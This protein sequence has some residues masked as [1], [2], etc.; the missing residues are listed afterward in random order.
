MVTLICKLYKTIFQINGHHRA[1]V[2]GLAG[3]G[4]SSAPC[5]HTAPNQPTFRAYIDS[6][7]RPWPQIT[8]PR[9]CGLP[10]RWGPI[11]GLWGPIAEPATLAVRPVSAASPRLSAHHTAF[12]RSCPCYVQACVIATTLPARTSNSQH[13]VTVVDRSSFFYFY[14]PKFMFST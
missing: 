6:K 14:Y 7:A 11:Y 5:D 9:P 3:M 12:V 13:L 4:P 2:R 8:P 1:H 10:S